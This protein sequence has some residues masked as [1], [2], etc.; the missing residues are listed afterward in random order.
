MKKYLYL[1]NFD[2]YHIIF[3]I[4]CSPLCRRS[5]QAVNVTRGET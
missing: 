1:S 5:L 3:T 2:I 4:L